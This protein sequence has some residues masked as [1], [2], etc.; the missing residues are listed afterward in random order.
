VTIKH[1]ATAGASTVTT[2]I[3]PTDDEASESVR[4]PTLKCLMI[5]VMFSFINSRHIISDVQKY[6]Y[7]KDHVKP[8][9]KMFSKIT[10]KGGNL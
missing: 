3:V 9:A 7:L 2:T 4:H 1:D 8:P 5:L 6:T 10:M